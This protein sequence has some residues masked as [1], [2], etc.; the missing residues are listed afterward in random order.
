MRR[1]KKSLSKAILRGG[2][3]NDTAKSARLDQLI[4]GAVESDLMLVQLNLRDKRG[5]PPTFLDLLKEIREA[6][7]LE[8]A[9]RCLRKPV[10]RQQVHAVQAEKDAELNPQSEA[11]LRVD[12]E[13]LK[14]RLKD[15]RNMQSLTIDEVSTKRSKERSNAKCSS[16]QE[17]QQ[18]RAEIN[19]FKDQVK[20]MTVQS[21]HYSRGK[22][23]YCRNKVTLNPKA[24]PFN[25]QTEE[26]FTGCFC[27]RCGENGHIATKC[28]APENS[29]KVI[30]KLI[31]QLRGNSVKG[32]E[33][34]GRPDSDVA[35]VNT[36]EASNTNTYLPEGFVGPSSICKIQ[37][38][39]LACDALIDS[40]SNVTI[41]FEGWYEKYLSHVA[42]QP[43]S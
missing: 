2:L 9:R 18:L 16:N 23:E 1:L 29:S 32:G 3:P 15:Q 11:Q 40:G 39:D 6:E 22:P 24:V 33:S 36:M 26:E 25:P 19:T 27:Y 21:S 42:I 7:D 5:T 20:V 31:R 12:V 8:A 35:S 30:K 37:V 34:P 4:K 41:I 14:A 38:N 13:E 10:S 28:A 43:I 17:M